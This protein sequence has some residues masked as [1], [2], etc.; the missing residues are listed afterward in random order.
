MGMYDYLGDEQ[1]KCFYV[2]I[3][4]IDTYSGEKEK[5]GIS[6]SGGCLRGYRRGSRVP[7]KTRYYNYGNDFMVF[8]FRGFFG[9]DEKLVHIIKQGRYKRSV[10]F[11]HIP[12]RYEI[13]LVVDNYG[14]PLNIHNREDFEKIC[15]DSKKYHQMYTDLTKESSKLMNDTIVRFRENTIESAEL[16][17]IMDKVRKENDLAFERSLKIFN[18]YWRLEEDNRGWVIGGILECFSM[19]Y[20]KEYEK[21]LIIELFHS[22]L[23][24][25]NKTLNSV[26]TDYYTW[27]DEND[28]PYSQS[29]IENLFNVYSQEM[30]EN[31][32]KEYEVE[33]ENKRC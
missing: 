30:P 28:V 2:P 4:Y 23:N 24:K 9:E 14:N 6:A 26:L 12:T 10:H 29:E 31:V 27:C 5:F 15:L 22:A 3:V 17:E 33:K 8:D 25:E 20:K 32:R 16:E 1:V 13:G 19:D 11:K 7:T 21:Y 18:D